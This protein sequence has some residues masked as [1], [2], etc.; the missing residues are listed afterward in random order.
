MKTILITIF[1]ISS[2]F[3]QSIKDLTERPVYNSIKTTENIT[4]DGNF[5]EYAW[6]LSLIHI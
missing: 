5:D 1:T 2:V 3:S 6:S 4:I